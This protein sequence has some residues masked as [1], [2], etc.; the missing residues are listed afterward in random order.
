MTYAAEI[1]GENYLVLTGDG[2]WPV[3]TKPRCK[4]FSVCLTLLP[5]RRLS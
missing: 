4:T 5:K 2:F 3:L 1:I